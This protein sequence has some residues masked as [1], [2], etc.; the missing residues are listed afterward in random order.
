LI[1]L[2]A[3]TGAVIATL[4]LNDPKL[5]PGASFTVWSLAIAN[6]PVDLI[7]KGETQVAACT[8]R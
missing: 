8:R 2:D 1:R 5:F 4:V 7:P 3:R 6:V